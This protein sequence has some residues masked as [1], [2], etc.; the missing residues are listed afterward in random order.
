MGMCH[1][2]FPLKSPLRQTWF[3]WFSQ[4]L[5]FL[6]HCGAG[7]VQSFIPHC[8]DTDDHNTLLEGALNAHSM[9]TSA[10]TALRFVLLLWSY[11]ATIVLWNNPAKEWVLHNYSCVNPI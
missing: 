9:H 10:A 7:L 1:I 3:L 6:H 4:H 5:M 11:M 2:S 8:N